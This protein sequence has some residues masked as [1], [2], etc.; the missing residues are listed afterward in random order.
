MKK[1]KKGK[2]AAQKKEQISRRKFVRVA[3]G[4]TL[5]FGMGLS[6][7]KAWHGWHW[8]GPPG[9]T[10][11]TGPPSDQPTGPSYWFYYNGSKS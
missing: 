9:S 3:A 2:L 7:A 6:N 11:P 5:A 4:T 8:G 1:G 10:P